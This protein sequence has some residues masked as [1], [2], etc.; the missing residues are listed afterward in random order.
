MKT[1]LQ[2]LR[3]AT[4]FML[5]FAAGSISM[6]LHTYQIVSD[7]LQSWDYLINLEKPNYIRI[8]GVGEDKK[9]VTIPADSL[10]TWIDKD[11]L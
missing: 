8:R 1:L 9:S 2:V 5:G 4:I 11:N 10:V 7:G 3:V 6:G